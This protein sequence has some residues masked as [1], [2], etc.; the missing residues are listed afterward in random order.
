MTGAWTETGDSGSTIFILHEIFYFLV[1][2]SINAG[3][4]S[5]NTH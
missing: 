5:G 1:V 2:P 3:L 4:Q